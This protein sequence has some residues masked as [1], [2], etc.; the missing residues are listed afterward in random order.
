[1]KPL[2][3]KRRDPWTSIW[4]DKNRR[5]LQHGCCISSTFS[6]TECFLSK[7]W[8]KN[9]T[10]GFSLLLTN[11]HNSLSNT[12]YRGLPGGSNVPQVFPCTPIQAPLA[13]KKSDL[14]ALNALGIW[15]NHFSLFFPYSF[16]NFVWVLFQMNLW[17]WET[18]HFVHVRL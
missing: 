10:R 3:G 18:F 16:Q 2:R 5:R 17:L 13:S 4:C 12:V 11:F 9:D 8:A 14:S 15:S 1:M 6:R 7:R